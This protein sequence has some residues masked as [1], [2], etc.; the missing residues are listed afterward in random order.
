MKYFSRTVSTRPVNTANVDWDRDPSMVRCLEAFG[1]REL[2]GQNPWHAEGSSWLRSL[3]RA[4]VSA[5]TPAD[6]ERMARRLRQIME[7]SPWAAVGVWRF[8]VTVAPRGWLEDPALREGFLAAL[9]T[10]LT[11]PCESH[12]RYRPN[13]LEEKLI[14][15]TEPDGGPLWK[16]LS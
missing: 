2:W 12:V 15:E 11:D 1:R 9:R 10:I 4:I 7:I 3:H 5:T 13:L 14:R 6:E 16:L 8:V